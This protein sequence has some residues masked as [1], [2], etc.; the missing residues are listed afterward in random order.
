MS[1]DHATV[2]RL[3]RE[4]SLPSRGKLP[5]GRRRPDPLDVFAN[6]VVPIPKNSAGSAP[7]VWIQELMRGQGTQAKIATPRA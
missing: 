2:Y 5:R 7:W 3:T 6:E 4:L 1:F